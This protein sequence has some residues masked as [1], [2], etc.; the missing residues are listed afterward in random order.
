M[1]A[2]LTSFVPIALGSDSLLSVLLGIVLVVIAYR[3][4]TRVGGEVPSS[5]AHTD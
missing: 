2:L 4:H 5:V 1:N 3:L